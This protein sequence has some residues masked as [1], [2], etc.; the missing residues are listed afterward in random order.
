MGKN[1]FNSVK[2]SKPKKNL[3]DLSHDVKFS[4]NMGNLYPVMCQEAIPGD[5]WNIGCETMLR[6]A[7][8]IAPVMHRMD[9]YVHYFFV[10]TR[11]LWP[12]WEKY[13]TN[14]L[15]A[16]VLPAV[17][18]V[19][20]ADGAHTDLDD[21]MG[22][23]RPDPATPN[24]DLLPFGHAAYQ[25]I[26]NEFYRDQ[27]LSAA[28]DYELTDGDNSSN[29]DLRQMRKRAWEHDYFTS[30]LPFAQ[31]GGAVDIPIQL[32]LAP[33]K[34]NFGVPSA[35]LE[36]K[37]DLS[38]I[39]TDV[40]VPVEELTIGGDSQLYADNSAAQSTGTI[41]ELRRAFKL[42]EW[43]EKSAR[44]GS[45]YVENILSFFGVRSPD[46]RLQRPEYITGTK[47]PVI[48]SEVLNNS[49]TATAPQGNMAGHAFSANA[50]RYGS[51]FVEEHGYVM[52][53]MSVLPKTAYQNGYERMWLK[54]SPFEH[55][56]PQFAHIGE[57]EVFNEEVYIDTA[58]PGGTFGYVPRYAEY[59]FANN[60]VAGDF[61]TS[62]N[63]WHAG[64]IFSSE[65]TLNNVFVESNPTDRIFAVL[66]AGQDH[67]YCMILHKI[68]VIRPM[69]KFGTPT[70]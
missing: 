48:I 19:P 36:V 43:L 61:R 55:F 5:K 50:G 46:K 53:I 38:G 44:G 11:L 18:T 64:R 13:I 29:G 16:G 31:K 33:V 10:P 66:G 49:D 51:Y 54:K 65:P 57:Q 70:F 59:K 9:V 62:L 32:G 34:F 21:Y 6:F 7:P 45:R 47:S 35:T 58:T 60:R 23:P 1:I 56:W 69:P 42:Q 37:T 4:L 17:P 67:L 20:H 27:N 15:V 26:W 3:F 12:N 63:F 68:T 40:S 30:A 28:V 22:W 39:P 2:M 41:N 8:L 24:I 52:G 25:F 14:T